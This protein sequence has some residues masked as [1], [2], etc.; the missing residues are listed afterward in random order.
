MVYVDDK[1][2]FFIYLREI[3]YDD[4]YPT[5]ISYKVNVDLC[6]ANFKKEDSQ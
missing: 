3:T 4:G 2:N 6:V 1:R 5:N